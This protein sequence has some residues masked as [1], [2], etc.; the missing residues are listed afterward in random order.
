MPTYTYH[1]DNCG[2]RFD[3][4][5][6][7]SD[8]PLRRCPEC[9]KNTVRRVLLASAIVFKGSGWYATDNRSA[10]G[11]TAGKKSDEASEKPAAVPE[12]KSEPKI[13]KKKETKETKAR[14]RDPD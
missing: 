9:G 7:F 13:E 11:Q 6:K 5:Q 4:F 3:K 8:K 12:A 1:C 14:K 10:S 2:V